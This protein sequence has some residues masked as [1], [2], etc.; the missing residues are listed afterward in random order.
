MAMLRSLRKNLGQNAAVNRQIVTPARTIAP[1]NL[2]VAHLSDAGD[3]TQIFGASRASRTLPIPI[4]TLAPS[5]P[6]DISSAGGLFE[7]C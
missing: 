3:V 5:M 1:S 4:R 2:G 6:T 7:H